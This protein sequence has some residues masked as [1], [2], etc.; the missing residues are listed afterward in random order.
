M[1]RE[2]VGLKRG[3][4]REVDHWSLDTL[5]NRKENLRI[6]TRSQNNCNRGMRKDN[7]SGF[8]GVTR[9]RFKS[10]YWIA[11]IM[12]HGK[13]YNLGHFPTKEQAAQAYREAALRMHGEFARI[14]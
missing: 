12:H 5:D 2:I 7:T 14:D 8:K 9:H 10:G 11:Q 1:A 3:D 6:A 13:G 4:K